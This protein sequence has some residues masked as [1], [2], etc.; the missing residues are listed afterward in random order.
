MWKKK[1]TGN[2]GEEWE[3][4]AA[5]QGAT[6]AWQAPSQFEQIIYV[7][8]QIQTLLI[9]AKKKLLPRDLPQRGKQTLPAEWA[10]ATAT[11]FHPLHTLVSPPA[12]LHS[13]S[14]SLL[15]DSFG[16][17]FAKWLDACL[18]YIFMFAKKAM[19]VRAKLFEQGRAFAHSSCP[20]PTLSVFACL[21]HPPDM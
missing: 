18:E 5:A 1:A 10:D 13:P 15:R 4:G 19:R 12:P 6:L 14:H 2:R 11:G 21:S 7:F 3:A 16:G 17:T 9:F 20:S 8:C